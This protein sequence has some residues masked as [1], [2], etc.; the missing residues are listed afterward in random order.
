VQAGIREG[1]RILRVSTAVVRSAADVV[2]AVSEHAVGDAVEIAFA[3]DG[4]QQV[5][6]V[7]LA[8]MPSQ[9]DMTR[10]DLLGSPAPA[11]RDLE[12]VSG[13]LSA[14][15]PSLRGRVVVVD[16]WATWCAPCRL[17]MP[18]LGALQARYGAQGLSIV[19]ISTEPEDEVTAFAKRAAI[20]YSVAV[21]PHA[22]TTRSYG[23][24]SLPTLVIVDKRGVVR[25]VAI[26][27][28]PSADAHLEDLLQTLLAE[29][30]N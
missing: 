1:D 3:H 14:S 20:P 30:P 27:Y 4:K 21:D 29:S 25:D 13:N 24:I 5:A 6:T 2:H 23:V 11:W 9:E 8:S 16:F 10:M 7:R 17:T 12:I 22:T 26:G 28:D 18:K 15:L 19:G